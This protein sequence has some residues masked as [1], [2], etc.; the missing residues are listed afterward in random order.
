[1][2]RSVQT[3]LIALVFASLL[4][5]LFVPQ[6]SFAA[7]NKEVYVPAHKGYTLTTL[8]DNETDRNPVGVRF[9]GF[10][11]GNSD[12]IVTFDVYSSPAF[13]VDFYINDSADNLTE[14]QLAQRNA[15]LDFAE[16]AHN[17]INAVDKC[18]NTQYDG[19]NDSAAS[20]IYRY[21]QAEFGAVLQIDAHTYEMLKIAKEMYSVTDGAFNPAVYRLVDLW[22]FSSRIYSNGKFGLPYDRPVT[23]QEFWSNGYPLPEQKYI[24]AFSAP[25]F[26]DFSDTA[27]TLS[28][29]AD[30]GNY[31]VTKNVSAA[32]VDGVEYTQ[33]LDLG[34]IA[35]GYVVD[36]IRHKL[37][38]MGVDRFS[39]DAGSSS[40]AFGKDYLGQDASISLPDPFLP[41][42]AILPT[43]L[44]RI[45]VGDS[46]VS[47]SGQYV[48]NYT[49]D[50]V[51]YSHIIDGKL[52]AP[53]QTGV[54]LV[55]VVTPKDGFWAGKSDCLTT[56]LTVMGKDGVMDFING[57]LKDNGIKVVVLYKDLDGVQ[58][59]LSNLD[60]DDIF[61]KGK[62][63]SD[64]VWSVKTD[65]NGKLVY[66][67][68]AT[69]GKGNFKVLIIVLASVFGAGAVAIVVYHFVRGHK[70]ALKN[71]QAAR[72]DKPFKAADVGM[73]LVVVLLIVVLFGVFF[74]K[75]NDASMQTVRVMDM[76]SNESLFTYNVSLGQYSVN[77]EN[78][79]GWN[80]SVD[81]QSDGLTVTFSREINGEQRFNT[82]KITT[83][84]NVKVEMVDSK[85]GFH[86]DCV[87]TF[88]AVN[89]PGG[90]IVC[91]PNGVKIV[92]D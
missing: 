82:M 49:V 89:V 60:E 31:F 87:H 43:S 90:A 23:S 38:Q 37:G 69:V 74:G 73:Y 92:T 41:S 34:G 18:A 59:I 20:D 26:T 8:I 61:D 66:D 86:Q 45:V 65:E 78:I 75:K 27:V 35:K 83:S 71:V 13:V 91:S 72:S 36:L 52:G 63:Y 19:T 33:W 22:G 57:Y 67:G 81:K 5:C 76:A 54:R 16:E 30:S 39:V 62:T 48:R 56:A 51:E 88:G 55:S 85:C 40:M 17:L 4:A 77:T 84:G 24:N 47:T 7:D 28:A 58:R 70:K 2:K 79:N 46:T 21:N 14:A 11:F 53:A 12:I 3:I 50:G 1:M 6:Q 10:Y 64:F 9:S 68:S 29:D 25:A 42:A 15:L 44:G 80:I 32:N